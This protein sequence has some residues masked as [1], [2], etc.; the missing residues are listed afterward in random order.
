MSTW[1]KCLSQKERLSPLRLPDLTAARV[2]PVSSRNLC[3]ELRASLAHHEGRDPSLPLDRLLHAQLSDPAARRAESSEFYRQLHRHKRLFGV[4]RCRNH[5]KALRQCVPARAT[6]AVA[7]EQ[8]LLNQATE[9]GLERIGACSVLT[10]QVTP[11]H[12]PMRSGVVKDLHGQMGRR[13][14]RFLAL[15]LGGKATLTCGLTVFPAPPPSA[16]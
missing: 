12:P 13:D 3:A 2:L 6:S 9:R 16:L 7:H 15:N 8:T 5:T 11:G 1:T 10:H 4:D 14:S